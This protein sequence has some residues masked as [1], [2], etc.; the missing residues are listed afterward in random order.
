MEIEKNNDIN[1]SNVLAND[2]EQESFINTTIGKTINTGIDIGLRALLPDFIENKIIDLKNNLLEYGLK[3]GISKTISET[4][5]EG[6]NAIGIITGN[7]EDISQIQSAIKKG[8]TIDQ[9]SYALDFAINQVQDAGLIDNK[10][11]SVLK[12][13]KDTILNNI[14][15]NIE[16][17]F[18]NQISN[19]EN[20]DNYIDNWKKFYD[21][22]DFQGMQKEYNNIE[23]IMKDIIPFEKTIN[24]ARVV[25]NIHNLI[26]NNGEDF[27]L[28]DETIE[29]AKKLK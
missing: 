15:S 17:T 16:S 28:S 26:K 21:T 10:I 3:D 11:V 7:F 22:K 23:K 25:E 13:G 24:E 8:G 14:E 5:Q 1:V 18:Q 4:I 2:I 20:L 9:I 6:K 27:Q 12:N 19:I 29:L